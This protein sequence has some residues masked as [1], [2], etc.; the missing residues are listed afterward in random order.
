MRKGLFITFEGTDGCGKSTQIG[1][2]NEYLQSLG[3]ETVLTREPGGTEIS[4]R[5]RELILDPKATD[6]DPKTE[7]FLFAAARAQHVAQLI[8]PSV[9]AGKIVLCD[10][11]VDSSIAY[12]GYARGL[13]DQVEIINRYAVDGCMP[14]ITFFFDLPADEGKK[15][16]SFTD[17]GDRMEMEKIDFHRRVYEG[18]KA[19]AEKNPDRIVVIDASGSIEDIQKE[20][21]KAFDGAIKKQQQNS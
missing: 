10:R 2:F 17:K 13:G 14:D 7:M 20:I 4:E 9:E 11:F 12:Q 3:M 5:I 1:L 8:R 6:E 18:F 16:N 15:R 19:V 21:R